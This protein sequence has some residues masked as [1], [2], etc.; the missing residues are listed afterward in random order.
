M[1]G[2]AAA[3]SKEPPLADREAHNSFQTELFKQRIQ[4]F[5]APQPAAVLE[6]RGAFAA[7]D[8]L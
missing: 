4:V 7:H 3:S 6:V 5:L 8:V 1:A 2:M